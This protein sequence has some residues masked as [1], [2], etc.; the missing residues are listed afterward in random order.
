M[1]RIK[2]NNSVS[3]KILTMSAPQG[4]GWS[5][6][7]WNCDFDEMLGTYEIDPDILSIFTE[8]YDI[9]NDVSAFVDDSQIVV[10]SESLFLCQQ[11]ANNILAQIL[12][13]S[14][15]KKQSYNATKSRAV[16]F[17]KRPIPF[18]VSIKLGDSRIEV[19]SSNKL[20]GVTLDSKLNWYEHIEIQ[21]AKCKRLIFFLNSCCKLKWGLT[22]EVLSKIWTGCIEPIL[23]YGCPV[24]ISALKSKWVV[25][26]IESVQRLFAIKM[27]RGF[28]TISYEAALTLSG[29]P[30][31]I[32]RLHERVLSYAAK[33]PDH[34][35]GTYIPRSHIEDT[36]QLANTY[37]INVEDYGK[38]LVGSVVTPPHLIKAPN[39]STVS[40]NNYP[41]F[42]DNALNI[43]T[44]GSKTDFGTGCAFVIFKSSS[45]IE[46]GQS[47]LGGEN[48]VFQAELLAIRNSLRHLFKLR[49][50]ACF[51]DINIF[52]DSISSLQSIKDCVAKNQLARDIQ[53]YIGFF[54]SFTKVTLT[55]CKGHNNI[56]GNELADFF[57]KDAISNPNSIIEMQPPP[58]SHLKKT[59]RE[60]SGHDWLDRWRTSENGR[61]TYNFIPNKV[62]PHVLKHTLSHKITHVLTGHCRIF[63]TVVLVKL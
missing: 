3:Q 36:L 22:R 27:I 15:A 16:V 29:L 45:S 1:I 39:V 26:K 13:K 46:H 60:K 53:K 50:K 5:P 59:V 19:S 54:S 58:I 44:D 35:L 4:A 23:L 25:K 34:Y 11:A 32:S 51:S 2:I 17:T 10:V 8:N 30:P 28:K 33:H 48:S 38:G 20:L 24:W 7:L 47:K 12:E 57:A 61:L 42:S 6:F 14:N 49:I 9:E 31:I 55:W 21:T 40:L 37:G 52:T 62:P 41:L 63:T 56:L 18:N 43:Y